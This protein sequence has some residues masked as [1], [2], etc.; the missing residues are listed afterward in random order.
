MANRRRRDKLALCRKLL[1][2]AAEDA[3]QPLPRKY[4]SLY[5]TF[6]GQSLQQCP[7]G[8]T[9]AMKLTE[10]LAPLSGQATALPTVTTRRA[11]HLRLSIHLKLDTSW[12]VSQWYAATLNQPVP[13]PVVCKWER[14]ILFVLR[15][16]VAEE[17]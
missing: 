11:L 8:R 10:Y 1:G 13:P 12:G 16:L 17:F 7:A 14:R 5:E 15:F 3:N 4:Q 6:S 9:G 2:G